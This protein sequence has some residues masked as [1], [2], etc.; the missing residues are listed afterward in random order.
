I[1]IVDEVLAVGDIEFVDKCVAHMRGLV[2]QGRTL[3]FVSH[4]LSLVDRLCSQCLLLDQGRIAAYGQRDQVTEQ[5]FQDLMRAEL[6]NSFR[7]QQQDK[8][9]SLRI[10]SG[11]VMARNR[12][13]QDRFDVGDSVE[14]ELEYVISQ[15]LSD[16]RLFLDVSNRGY[17]I[18][19][20]FES[21]LAPD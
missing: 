4:Q 6:V 11:R 16:I 17:C 14:I 10:E 8:S 7:H 21:D 12:S 5:Y 15:P 9:L 3:V 2:D 1:L 13:G 20:S 19:R 18:L